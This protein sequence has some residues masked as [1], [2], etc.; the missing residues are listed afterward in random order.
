MYYLTIHELNKPLNFLIQILAHSTLHFWNFKAN[1]LTANGFSFL[2]SINKID[3]FE[4]F[5]V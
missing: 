5:P 1:S 2:T 3:E 4:I